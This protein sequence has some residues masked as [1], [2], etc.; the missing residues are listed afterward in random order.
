MQSSAQKN[1][2]GFECEEKQ[3][4]FDGHKILGQKA[5]E[6]QISAVLEEDSELWRYSPWLHTEPEQPAADT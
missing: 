5:N 4:H 3:I 2:N 6:T 1:L